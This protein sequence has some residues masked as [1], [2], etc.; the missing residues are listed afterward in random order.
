V[1]WTALA[2]PEDNSWSDIIYANGRFV[3]VANFGTNQVMYADW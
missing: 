2:A 1:Q 3:A